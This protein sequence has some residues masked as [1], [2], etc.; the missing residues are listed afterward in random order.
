MT[1][2]V[3]S[4][5][6]ASGGPGES[7]IRSWTGLSA[8][9]SNWGDVL[10]ARRVAL[11]TS[12]VFGGVYTAEFGDTSAV[13]VRAAE[14][15]YKVCWEG[16]EHG[17]V[18]LVEHVET[19]AVEAMKGG[20]SRKEK[21]GSS[22]ARSSCWRHS[23]GLEAVLIGSAGSLNCIFRWLLRLRHAGVVTSAGWLPY[24]ASTIDGM[25][26][27]R[28][29]I[30]PHLLRDSRPDA[31]HIDTLL[32]PNDRQNVKLMQEVECAGSKLVDSVPVLSAKTMTP[33]AI[34][35]TKG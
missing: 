26:L 28:Q 17:T 6:S 5:S 8:T 21:Q 13:C 30:K 29:L 32:N 9:M 35:W 18:F 31:Q 10:E 33:T 19:N 20:E 7:I 12:G 22:F 4:R 3:G 11:G 24:L 34:L 2:R 16:Q 27:T 1:V 23:F 15:Q 14:G 25:V